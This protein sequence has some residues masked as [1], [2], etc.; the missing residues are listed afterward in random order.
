MVAAV[1]ASLLVPGRKRAAEA[2]HV[3]PVVEPLPA[4]E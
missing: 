4:V 1:A 3:V 2:P